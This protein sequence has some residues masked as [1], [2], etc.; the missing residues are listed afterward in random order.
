MWSDQCLLDHERGFENR[1][2]PQANYTGADGKKINYRKF[3]LDWEGYLKRTHVA[4]A[5]APAFFPNDLSHYRFLLRP[6]WRT[7]KMSQR[8]LLRR[9]A[10]DRFRRVIGFAFEVR[11]V[12][13]MLAPERI[14]FF[15]GD[16]GRKQKRRRIEGIIA[17]V[18]LGSVVPAPNPMAIHYESTAYRGLHDLVVDVGILMAPF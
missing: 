8:T 10:V 17:P 6:V 9:A 11:A 7:R 4:S 14:R 12:S 1:S 15:S 2:V 3:L 16:Y 13:Q 5:D 18:G